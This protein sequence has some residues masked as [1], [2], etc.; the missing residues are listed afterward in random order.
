MASS[1][2]VIQEALRE[3]TNLKNA[4]ARQWSG[5]LQQ[6]QPPPP[7]EVHYE[8]TIRSGGG[9]GGG[10]P[11]LDR[12]RQATSAAAAAQRFALPHRQAFHWC[13]PVAHLLICSS[14]Y[15]SVFAAQG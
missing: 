15:A 1:F 7:P 3:A 8:S 9:G 5:R 4:S 13:S 6:P 12:F 2:P 10:T 11:S 14:T